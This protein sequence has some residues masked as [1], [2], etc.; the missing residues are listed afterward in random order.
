MQNVESQT[1]KPSAPF[2]DPN[3]PRGQTLAGRANG[4]TS[5]HLNSNSDNRINSNNKILSGHI[6]GGQ[7]W[8]K[9]GGRD[10]QPYTPLALIPSSNPAPT[11]Q[12]GAGFSFSGSSAPAPGKQKPSVL[13]CLRSIQMSYRCVLR[14]VVAPT[15]ATF[16][17]SGGFVFSSGST[18]ASAPGSKHCTVLVIL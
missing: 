17:S 11:H 16:G 3:E 7:K 12:P 18:P 6:P 1:K 15:P 5:S 14:L 10:C 9:E 8:G 2:S 4:E 13:R